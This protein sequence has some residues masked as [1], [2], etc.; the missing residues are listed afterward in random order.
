MTKKALDF[1]ATQIKE[2][3]FLGEGAKFVTIPQYPE[4]CWT[5]LVVNAVVHRDYSIMGTDIIVKIF[6][7]H[8][9]VE[10]PG[11]LPGMVRLN[12]IRRIHFSRNPKIAQY[13]HEYDLVKEF[14]EGVDRLFREMESAGNPAPEYRLYDFMLKAKLSSAHRESGNGEQ[15]KHELEGGQTGGQRGSQTTDNATARMIL[16]AIIADPAITRLKISELIGIS[17]AAVQKHIN[18]LKKQKII[19]RRGGDFGGIW[20][21]L[22]RE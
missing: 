6:D 21:I 19:A 18:K 11:I 3:S 10:S 15:K 14:G 17:P 8:L 5:E 1:I 2:Y 4:F 13:M 22:R 9:I 12:N 7:N 16:D 20:K